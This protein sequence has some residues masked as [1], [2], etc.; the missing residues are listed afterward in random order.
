MIEWTNNFLGIH[1]K[2][3]TDVKQLKYYWINKKKLLPESEWKFLIEKENILKVLYLA[4]DMSTFLKLLSSLYGR[5][6]DV[7]YMMKIACF[8]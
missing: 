4:Q 2:L 6:F 3:K 7:W 5:V 1:F 8:Q